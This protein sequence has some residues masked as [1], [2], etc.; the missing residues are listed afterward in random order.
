MT[1]KEG[2]IIPSICD[3][4]TSAE[5]LKALPQILITNQNAICH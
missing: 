2:L 1:F 3:F 4:E 5:E